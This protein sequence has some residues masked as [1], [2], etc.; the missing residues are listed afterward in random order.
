MNE[1]LDLLRAQFDENL[2]PNSRIT[3]LQIQPET[4]PPR[5]DWKQYSVAAAA[6]PLLLSPGCPFLSTTL[7]P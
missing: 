6:P 1:K 3:V 5:P 7:E 4:D 2:A